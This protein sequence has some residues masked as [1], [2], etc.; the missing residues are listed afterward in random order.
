MCVIVPHG[1]FYFLFLFNDPIMTLKAEEIFSQ[2]FLIFWPGFNQHPLS[3]L[4][5]TLLYPPHCP[6]A[7]I[8]LHRTQENYCKSGLDP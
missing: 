8:I 4:T 3:L 7:N 2:V 6:E 1:L 5:V